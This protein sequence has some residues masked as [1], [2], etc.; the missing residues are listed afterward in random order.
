MTRI[1]EAK[2]DHAFAEALLEVPELLSEVLAGGRFARF[3]GQASILAGQQAAIRHKAKHW[4]KHWW[5]RLPDGTES[6]TDVFVVLEAGSHRFALH[7][8]N[9]PLDGKLTFKQ[10][11]DYRRRAAF[12]AND[13]M[14]LGYTEFETILLCPLQFSLH[15]AEQARQFDRVLAYEDIAPLIPLF[16]EAVR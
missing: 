4:W 2:L 9:K 8:E 1:S 14:W 12:K 6:E 10:A 11:S 3:A 16:A 15:Y 5:C 13:H 7:I